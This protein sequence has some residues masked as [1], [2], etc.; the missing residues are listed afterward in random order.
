MSTINKE[1]GGRSMSWVARID[2]VS[3]HPNADTLDICTVGG[4]KVVTRTGQF[5]TG[6]LGVYISIDSWVPDEVAPFLSKGSVPKKYNGVPG[7]RLKTIKLR[8]Q[9]SQGLLMSADDVS[10]FLSCLIEGEVLDLVL[11]IQKWELPI[12]PHLSGLV[13]GS[14]PSF[15]PK[16][17]QERV[18]NLT[19]HVFTKEWQH[20]LWEVTVKMDGSSMTVFW[21]DSETF[22]VCSRNLML[23]LNQEGNAFV[24]MER[25]MKI[26]EKLAN[27][28]LPV[29]IQGEL[30]G[31]GIQGN[32]EQLLYNQFFIFD[33]FDIASGKYLSPHQRRIFLKTIGLWPYSVPVMHENISLYNLGL[34]TMDDFLDFA[35][36]SSFKE[37]VKREGVVFKS[38]TGQ[39]SFKV[40][41]NEYLLK[42]SNR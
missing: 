12:S 20:E 13:K 18:Q 8:G 36:G 40:I 37:N 17:D 24:N 16:T 33:V 22:G 27:C 39:K 6:D 23:R 1:K 28:G 32:N 30:C 11:G 15:I 3:K 5:K 26:L 34:A 9:V 2:D 38:Q 7:Y 10:K 25:E 4:W 41:S 35:D 14:F 42:N 29:A 21:K 31:P 19:K